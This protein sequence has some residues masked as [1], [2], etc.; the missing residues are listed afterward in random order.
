M[1]AFV[2]KRQK[3]QPEKTQ[4][5]GDTTWL[6]SLNEKHICIYGDPG[7]GKTAT[8]LNAFPNNIDFSYD[9][10]HSK[11]NTI[12]FL[13]R[14]STSDKDVI[15]D[16]LDV[17][18][19][20]DLPGWK[21]IIN[22]DY[23]IS[24]GR[25]ILVTNNIKK[26]KLPTFFKCIHVLHPSDKT[27]VDIGK[28]K[29]A[30]VTQ[31]LNTW[32]RS[33]RNM[34]IFM[35]DIEQV[36][37]FNVTKSARDV[38]KTPYDYICDLICDDTDDSP[39][40]TLGSHIQEHGFMWCILQENYVDSANCDYEK[41]AHLMSDAE[42]W[43]NAVY[44]TSWEFMQYFSTSAIVYPAFL[45][46]HTLSRDT[47]RPGSAWTKYSNTRMKINK[48]K[49]IQRRHNTHPLDINE[50]SLVYLAGNPVVFH[51]KS[52]ETLDLDFLNGLSACKKSQRE[53]KR[54]K[55]EL[56]SLGHI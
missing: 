30:T 5:I 14:I 56:K 41:I 29:G 42:V 55:N 24:K 11:Q 18:Q 21:E 27:I 1:E 31:S 40:E 6:S 8:V 51:N 7:C 34:H 52:F 19:S 25:L 16:G 15:I 43:D 37:R 2:R 10:L 33:K 47:I 38:F 46:N 35:Q 22:L 53:L 45:I 32:K 9:I 3:S 26:L 23:T 36:V 49:T 4:F 44:D 54:V 12:E 13:N 50:Y 20:F 28:T 17:L 48:L 39:I